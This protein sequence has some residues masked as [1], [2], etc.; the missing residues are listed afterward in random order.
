MTVGTAR[1][2]STSG[3]IN[4]VGLVKAEKL[5]EIE[6][7]S[8]GVS[9]RNDNGHPS[10]K[11]RNGEKDGE[12]ETDRQT[13]R[14]RLSAH[15]STTAIHQRYPSKISVEDVGPP[16]PGLCGDNERRWV[17]VGG[18]GYLLGVH[19]VQSSPVDPFVN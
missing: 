13:E 9:T 14:Q 16:S 18:G 3:E 2:R 11:V 19:R 7:I 8:G 1:M 4:V 6:T 12:R 10:E 17:A 5:V 15:G